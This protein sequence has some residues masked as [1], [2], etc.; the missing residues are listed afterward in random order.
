[1]T[2]EEFVAIQEEKE[3]ERKE[4]SQGENS[5]GEFFHR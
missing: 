2:Q 3:K 4:N 5:Q 1:V